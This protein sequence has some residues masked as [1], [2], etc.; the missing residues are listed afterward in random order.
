MEERFKENREES[1]GTTKFQQIPVFEKRKRGK[2]HHLYVSTDRDVFAIRNEIVLSLRHFVDVRFEV[3]EWSVFQILN[4]F[5]ATDEEIRQLHSHIASDVDSLMAFSESFQEC[6]ACEKI[7]SARTLR[8]KFHLI[9]HVSSWKP[10]AIALARVLASKPHSADVERLIST[11]NKVKTHSRASLSS[12]TIQNYL[13]IRHNMPALE[14]YDVRS[15]VHL[16]LSKPRRDR[17]PLLFKRQEWYKG[18]FEEASISLQN[19][20]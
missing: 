11:Y 3:K 6:G 7:K 2:Q 8:E 15:A 19:S 9:R 13:Y 12:S 5:E 17:E 1:D 10:V 18:V 16:W 20:N 4:T 14:N